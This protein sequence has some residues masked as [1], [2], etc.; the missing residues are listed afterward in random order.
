MAGGKET[1]RQKMIGIMY[2]VLM[3]M[4]AINV[5]DTIL[6]AFS[7]INN[8]LKTS[9]SN[10]N[11]S[12]VQS[13]NAF[14]QTKLKENPE[15]ARPIL[16]KIKQAQKIAAEL[17]SYIESVKQEMI[18]A[19]GNIDPKTGEITNRD[20]LDV[21]P[22]IMWAEGKE[23]KGKGY[24]IQKK[25]NDTREKLTAL[26]DERDRSSVS[27]SLE[28]KNADKRS[29]SGTKSDW[30]SS[31]FGEGTPVTASVTILSKIQ[32]DIKNA[33]NAVVRKFLSK[34]DEALVN[35]D[36]FAAVVVAPTS[37]LIQGQPYKAEVFLTAYDS[38]QNP[39][40]TVGGSKLGTKDGR[41][42]Y[43]VNTSSEGEFKWKG[44][45]RVQQTDGKV[46]VYETPEQTYRVAR[47]S[48]VVSPDKMNVFYMGVDNPVS[49]SAPGIAKEKIRVNVTGGSISGANGKYV[50]RVSGGS[51]AT[52]SVSAEID[53]GKSQVLGTTKF[54]IKKVP[55]PI[56][57]FAG[58]VSGR[59]PLATA[60]GINRLEAELKD[61][62]FD[63]N[64]T[65]TKF[66]VI[67][68]RYRQDPLIF[69]SNDGSLTGDMK[70]IMA[71]LTAGDVISFQNITVYGEDK[72]TRNLD[73]IV[74]V[75]IN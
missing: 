64:F 47:P 65:V 45:I 75:S 60:K 25:V 71:T 15:R 33:E 74:S 43:T 57:T 1:P 41:G 48:A 23:N 42:V 27:F 56:A 4:L 36:A 13:I 40:I 37:Y 53:P 19:A 69:Q 26:L 28:A 55:D 51:E 66:T 70:R 16:D 68:S 11:K 20:D 24:L 31:S 38:K 2:L 59:V 3:A 52:V 61:F 12:L 44:T 22:R 54:R 14:E 73:N 6:N 30:V 8:S 32:A 67:F 34:M 10:V 63:L 39:D 62:D 72:T 17:D 18:V 5:S 46:K 49:V 7:T 58:K 9:T 29:N 35:L 50:V 21:S